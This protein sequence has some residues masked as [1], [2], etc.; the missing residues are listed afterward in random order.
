MYRAIRLGWIADGC[1]ALG[2]PQ[3]VIVRAA[4]A[5]PGDEPLSGQRVPGHTGHATLKCADTD[6]ESGAD[7]CPGIADELPPGAGHTA[8]IHDQVSVHIAVV[9]NTGAT[10]T[11]GGCSDGDVSTQKYAVRRPDSL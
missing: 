8:F 5:R 7:Q 4:A 3:R 9:A 2:Q 1:T 6:I 10:F 11:F